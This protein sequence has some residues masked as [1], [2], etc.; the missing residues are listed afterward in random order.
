MDSDQKMATYRTVQDSFA[1]QGFS[2]LTCDICKFSDITETTAGYVCRNCG[3]MLEAQKLQYDRPYNADLIQY[4][5]GIGTTQ[6]G[7]RK[8]RVKSPNSRSLNRLSKYN[9]IIDNDK[10]AYAKA[11]REFSRIL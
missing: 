2:P 9:N 7:T 11:R 4:A 8:E 1:V 6:V 3:I 5:T 10:I